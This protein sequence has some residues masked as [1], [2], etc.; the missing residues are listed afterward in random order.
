MLLC[1]K[2]EVMT[3]IKLSL[4]LLREKQTPR[5]VVA[6]LDFFAT[7]W[8]EICE[9]FFPVEMQYVCKTWLFC[10]YRIPRPK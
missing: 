5:Y 10:D 1:L 2:R 9:K 4:V 8:P 6:R 3:R 7:P